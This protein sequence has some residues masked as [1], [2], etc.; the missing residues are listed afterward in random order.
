M[1]V[2]QSLDGKIALPGA[3]TDLSS[4][5]GWC[6][7]HR[8][9][10]EHDGVLV[11]SETV[12]LDDPKLTVRKWT[13]SDPRRIVL[14]SRLEVP[15]QAR[16]FTSSAAP[17]LV[18]GVAGR[19]SERDVARVRETGAEVRLVDGDAAGLVSL[20]S[21]LAVIR[22]WGVQRLLIEGGARVLT[23]FLREGLLDEAS[24]EIVPRVFGAQ[25]VALVGDLAGAAQLPR[26]ADVQ[27]DRAGT[28]VIV[29]GRFVH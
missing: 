26:L 8:A 20:V 9:R 23:S 1:H 21:A 7:A 29:R 3:R 6:A 10:A 15:L 24:I 27:F 22:E 13:G 18:I 28:S 5:E 4:E 25:G 17:V 14:A 19:A 12:R 11:G 16:L 2:A